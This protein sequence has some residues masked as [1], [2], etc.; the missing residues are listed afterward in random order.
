MFSSP[1]RISDRAS[2]HM[3]IRSI[4]PVNAS[5]TRL[6]ERMFAE[7]VSR[8][9]P[10]VVSRSTA[11]L[12][13]SSRPGARWISSIRTGASRPA[14][15]PAGSC[16]AACNVRSSSSVSVRIGWSVVAISVLSVVLP[17]CRA[18]EMSTI[19][20]CRRASTTIGRMRRV[21]RRV[22]ILRS[23]IPPSPARVAVSRCVNG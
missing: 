4:R 13:S 8:K 12:I 11:F 1:P 2:G 16:R 18:P 3:R 19:R 15:K 23:P 6:E 17:T 10:G 9:R 14:I 21:N 5:M 7:P 20:A 22:V